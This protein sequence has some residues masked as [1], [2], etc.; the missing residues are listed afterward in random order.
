MI[1]Q[2]NIENIFVLTI[3]T[4]KGNSFKLTDI[5][6]LYNQIIITEENK[7]IKALIITGSNRTFSIGGNL[8][9]ISRFESKD[10]IVEYFSNIDKLLIKLFKFSKPL[11]VAINGHAIGLGFLI[12]LCA[13]KIVC[14]NNEKIK[15]GL[16][17][18]KI[19]MTIDGVM[20]EILNFNNICGK[21]LSNM[22]FDS[23]LMNVD[24]FYTKKIIDY[25]V[26][27][28][29]L[30]H[31]AFDLATQLSSNNEIAFANTKNIIR[32]NTLLKI[33]EYFESNS[34]YV[35]YEL[36]QNKSLKT[37]K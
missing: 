3:D 19:G 5:E 12:A 2:E 16:P 15:M 4:G 26:A 23:E 11:I 27:D 32:E 33:N 36:L 28:D 35:F 25:L 22:L 24:F 34:A 30:N 10:Q 21:N 13:D 8:D 17:E 6:E 18:L 29:S 1:H 20:K 7:D 14:I 9:E 31:K 37:E